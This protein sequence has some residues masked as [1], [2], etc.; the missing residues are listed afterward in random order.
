MDEGVF[1]GSADEISMKPRNQLEVPQMLAGPEYFDCRPLAARI[2]ARQCLLNQGKAC[3]VLVFGMK[4]LGKERAC[5]DCLD[6]REMRALPPGRSASAETPPNG[7]IIVTIDHLT[8]RSPS[9]PTT[10]GE[11]EGSQA[12][13]PVLPPEEPGLKTCAGPK[14][15]LPAWLKDATPAVRRDYLKG[16]GGG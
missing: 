13:K 14:K 5:L 4:F 9:P 7:D 11:G 8:A 12:G 16:Q 1:W 2:S 3:G 15:K 10:R 6:G